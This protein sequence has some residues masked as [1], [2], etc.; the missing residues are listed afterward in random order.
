ME[1]IGINDLPAK[2]RLDERHHYL[3]TL[4]ISTVALTAFSLLFGMLAAI[5]VSRISSESLGAFNL[6]NTLVGNVPLI[7]NWTIWIVGIVLTVVGYSGSKKRARVFNIIKT[8][9]VLFIELLL[10]VT[11]LIFAGR[12]ASLYYHGEMPEAGAMLKVY[13]G[14]MLAACVPLALF[15]IFVKK[16]LL[17][18]GIFYAAYLMLL[19]IAAAALLAAVYAGK[20]NVIWLAAVYGLMQPAAYVVMNVGGW[21][22]KKDR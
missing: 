11:L 6:G 20:L 1:S 7:A 17:I 10:G 16:N 12:I 8:A 18:M 19:A 15:G 13:A 4:P 21:R 9:V 14:F 2:K 3:I 22:V 5:F